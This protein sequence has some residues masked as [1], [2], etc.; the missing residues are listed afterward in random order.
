MTRQ[1]TGYARLRSG[2]KL[3]EPPI[4]LELPERT[5]ATVAVAWTIPNELVIPVAGGDLGGAAHAAEHA[6]IGLLPLFATCD[7]WDIGGLSTELP[8]GHRPADRLRLRRQR[9]RRRLRRARLRRRRP[10]AERHQGRHPQL[11]LRVR[12]PVLRP[13]PQVRQ[14]Q[15]PARQARRCRPAEPPARPRPDLTRTPAPTGHPT[16]C[17]APQPA[18]PPARTHPALRHACS[19]HS[20]APRTSAGPTDASRARPGPAS[21][22]PFP[23]RHHKVELFISVVTKR[24]M[25]P[26]SLRPEKSFQALRHNPFPSRPAT[27]LLNQSGQVCGV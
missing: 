3:R 9:G 10:L 1:V 11:P 25:W 18:R 20:P 27:T 26:L 7:R 4:P 2:R 21:P 22:T 24:A 14:R 8:P 5:L 13:V 19:R 23:A 17:T 16:T 6:S 15:L 12:L